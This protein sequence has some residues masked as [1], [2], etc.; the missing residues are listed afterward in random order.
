M[1]SDDGVPPDDAQDLV[2]PETVSASGITGIGQIGGDA[3]NV[4]TGNRGAIFNT[5]REFHWHFTAE[6]VR[7]ERVLL[8]RRDE[9]QIKKLFV[10]PSG[11]DEAL[12]ELRGERTVLVTGE[13]QTGRRTAAWCLLA[14]VSDGDSREVQV[15]TP[16]P[17][18]RQAPFDTEEIVAGDRLMVDLSET[19]DVTF[20]RAED[21]LDEFLGSVIERGAV[22][23]VMMPWR[24]MSVRPEHSRRTHRLGRPDG[25]AVL[26]RHFAQFNL[27]EP[28]PEHLGIREIVD[29]Y[30]TG[31]IARL[32]EIAAVAHR[33]GG[34]KG[35]AWLE[36]AVDALRNR[37]SEAVDLVRKTDG[38]PTARAL[39]CAVSLFHG[40]YPETVVSA[41]NRLLDIVARD[42]ERTPPFVQPGLGRRLEPIGARIDDDGRVRFVGLDT[43]AAVRAHFWTHFPEIYD[44]L[45]KW[46][47]ACGP[48]LAR[49]R[50]ST[51]IVQR[52]VDQ[53][54]RARRASDVVAVARGWVDANRSVAGLAAVALERGLTDPNH[55]WT[56]RRMCYDLVRRTGISSRFGEFLVAAC[57]EIIA[58]THPEQALLR[59]RY[60]AAHR[61][62]AVAGKAREAMAGVLARRPEKLQQLIMYLDGSTAE[63]RR[64]DARSFLDVVDPDLF[65]RAS[66]RSARP[67]IELSEVRSQLIA[68][69][70]DAL[71]LGSDLWEATFHRWL[72]AAQGA[73]GDRGL[74]VLV[75]AT[76]GRLDRIKAVQR[77][78]DRWAAAEGTAAAYGLRR[79]FSAALDEA[80]IDSVQN[81]ARPYSHAPAGSRVSEER[82]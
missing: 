51:D 63:Q 8:G 12:G 77:A 55:G 46:F 65:A 26:K 32:A 25:L 22:A 58:D 35:N 82:S 9:E 2:G 21:A 47:Q 13:P 45:R 67:L 80:L 6:R 30:G 62:E 48:V 18:E 42:R 81:A 44:D 78:A 3:R 15:V 11:W 23:A 54:L 16:D 64:A 61:D 57:R 14:N 34:G 75:D 38:D 49:D 4:F 39:L 17:D 10:K 41:T 40:T 27:P 33:R 29:G 1:T 66:S 68:L 31:E 24:P 69:W 53:V 37:E 70:R 71:D 43:A 20:A 79:R 28:S 7:R 36:E 76:D 5:H 56:F 52:F 59:L 72:V 19:D 74:A 73:A 50:E 60:L